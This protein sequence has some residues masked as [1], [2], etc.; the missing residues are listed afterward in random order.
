M[1]CTK[2][3]WQL[4]DLVVSLWWFWPAAPKVLNSNPGWGG[5]EFSK[6]TFISTQQKLSSLLITCGVRLEGTLSSVFYIEVSERC[7]TSLNIIGHMSD[8]QSSPLSLS[9]LVD[10][11]LEGCTVHIAIN[12]HMWYQ[13][14]E[15]THCSDRQPEQWELMSTITFMMSHHCLRYFW[16]QTNINFYETQAPHWVS[17]MAV[18]SSLLQTKKAETPRNVKLHA[19]QH[20]ETTSSFFMAIECTGNLFSL[21]HNKTRVTLPST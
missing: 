4:G 18:W 12:V 21:W 7:W 9:H 1:W 16:R 13:S 20:I 14:V 2:L 6:L 3:G 8:S 19:W 5:Q 10:L 11:A 15:Y 17:I